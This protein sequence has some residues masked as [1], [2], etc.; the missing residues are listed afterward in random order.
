MKVI[1]IVSNLYIICNYR[2]G[3]KFKYCINCIL[4]DV[5]YCIILKFYEVEIEIL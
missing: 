2:I 5:F 1:Y 4:S 3:F